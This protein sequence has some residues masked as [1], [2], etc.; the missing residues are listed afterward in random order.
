MPFSQLRRSA[1]QIKRLLLS[2]LFFKNSFS[3]SIDY[4]NPSYCFRAL[5][6]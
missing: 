4:M 1:Q 5:M 2:G 6:S 3:L